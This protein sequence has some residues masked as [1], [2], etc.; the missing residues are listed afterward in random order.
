M[1]VAAQVDH[2]LGRQ[3][4]DAPGQ[5]SPLD[6]RRRVEPCRRNAIDHPPIR[7]DLCHARHRTAH[8]GRS[9]SGYHDVDDADKSLD[10]GTAP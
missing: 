5:R 3:L 4:H 9:P 10:D 6:Q 7:T 1:P 2:D 8:S